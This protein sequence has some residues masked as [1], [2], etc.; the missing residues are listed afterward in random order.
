MEKAAVGGEGRSQ[1]DENG[2]SNA[3]AKY[4]SYSCWLVWEDKKKNF[5]SLIKAQFFKENNYVDILG[6]RKIFEKFLTFT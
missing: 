2:E 4:S 1:N 6:L 3:F 5:F